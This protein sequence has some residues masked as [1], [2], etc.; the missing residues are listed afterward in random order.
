MKGKRPKQ[1]KG[2]GPKQVK[3]VKTNEVLL[4]KNRFNQDGHNLVDTRHM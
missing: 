1:V 3:N 2:N 4:N